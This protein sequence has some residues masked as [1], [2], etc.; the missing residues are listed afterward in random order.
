VHGLRFTNL[1][2]R[3]PGEGFEE[4][5]LTYLEIFPGLLAF[6]FEKNSAAPPLADWL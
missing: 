5:E 6:R 1:E 2:T 4:T 3:K